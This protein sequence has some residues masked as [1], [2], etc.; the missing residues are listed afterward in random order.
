MPVSGMAYLDRPTEAGYFIFPDLSVRHEGKYKLSFNLYEETKEENDADVQPSNEQK[1]PVNNGPSSPDA[2]FDWRLEVKSAA[3]TVY[4]AKK[5]PGL[6]ESTALSRTVAEQGCRVRIRRDVRMRRREGKA[7]GD[8]EETNEDDYARV[9]RAPEQNDQY[10]ERSH[11]NGSDGGRVPYPESQRRMS[12]DYAS[13][14]YHNYTPSPVAGH[15]PPPGGLL[16]FGAQS[17]P[18]FSAPQPQFAQ[19]QAPAAQSYQSAPSAYHQPAPPQYRQPPPPAPPTHNNYA[20]DRQYPQSAYPTNPP[21]EQREPFEPEYRR[22]SVGYAPPHAPQS[23]GPYPAV[24]SVYNR[25]PYHSYPPRPHSPPMASS[26]ALPP[27][28]MP[29]IEKNYDHNTSPPG[30]LSSVSRIAPP[31]PSPSYERSQ[32]RSGS[33][34]QYSAPLQASTPVDRVERERNGKRTFDA[35]FNSASTNQPL[36]NGMRPSSSHH[37]QSMIDDDDSMSLEQ[38]KMQY[39]R[40]D[41]S[42]YSREL[43]TLE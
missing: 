20:Y 33:Y 40:A 11:S 17:G 41:G 8:F 29:S 28:K 9:G 1:K 30:P 23:S 32:E 25:P 43:P 27:L 26:V 5:F 38:L 19:P 6:A 37:N 14:E 10:R 18:Q 2:S 7:G 3:F 31:L 12:G 13:Q 39:K 16:N 21:R 34:S 36:Y 42:S 24:D 15:A 22:A 4:S 35:V